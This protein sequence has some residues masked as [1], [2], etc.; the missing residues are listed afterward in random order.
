[1]SALS[2][3]SFGD[4]SMEAVTA[5]LNAVAFSLPPP[6]PL[7]ANLYG[8]LDPV[9]ATSCLCACVCVCVLSGLC[10]ATVSLCV[11]ECVSVYVCACVSVGALSSDGV[12]LC[13]CECVSVYV[14]ACVSVLALIGSV[15]VCRFVYVFVAVY[16]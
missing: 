3:P 7:P 6:L 16:V 9:S 12:A 15:S 4:S 1:M 14:C 8:L 2:A 11:C 13:V 10:L 5:F